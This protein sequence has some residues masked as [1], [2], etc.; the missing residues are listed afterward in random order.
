[1]LVGLTAASWP[2]GR[3]RLLIAKRFLQNLDHY[4]FT[5][6]RDMYYTFVRDFDSELSAP[7]CH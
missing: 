1:M 4:L 3:P 6:L 2:G 7:G 5:K